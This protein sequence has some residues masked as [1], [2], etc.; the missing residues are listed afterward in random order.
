M[1]IHIDV[2]YPSN[3]LYTNVQVDIPEKGIICFIGDNGSGKSTLFKTL[4]GLQKSIKGNIPSNLINKSFI[5][6]DYINIP[7]EIKVRDVLTLIT[8][9]QFEEYRNV[10]PSVYE[11]I[12]KLNNR[13]IKVLS[14]G[15]RKIIEIFSALVMNKKYLFLDEALNTLDFYNKSIVIKILKEITKEDI[16]VF[17]ISHNFDEIIELNGTVY[18]LLP[19]KKEIRKLEEGQNNIETIKKLIRGE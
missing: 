1:Q 11:Y 15:E 9:N 2:G 18:I 4:T 5:I 13:K 19:K 7:D 6:S 17:Y 16:T 10:Y 12:A 14:S 8:N 3:L